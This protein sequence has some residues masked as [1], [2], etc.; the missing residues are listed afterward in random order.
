[1]VALTSLP[2]D[3]RLT[4]ERADRLIDSALADAAVL[5]GYDD[6]LDALDGDPAKLARARHLHALWREWLDKAGPVHNSAAAVEGVD[7]CRVRELHVERRMI[8]ALLRLPP[9]EEARLIAS[10]VAEN[11]RLAALPGAAFDGQAALAETRRRIAEWR[12]ATGIPKPEKRWTSRR[13]GHRSFHL[14]EQP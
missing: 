7:R 6:D 12:R 10:A 2:P 3:R 11:A 5:H 8:E 13:M 4:P 9:E 1:M 14:V